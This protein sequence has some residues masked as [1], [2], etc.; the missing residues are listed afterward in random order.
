MQ[1]DGIFS[2][3]KTQYNASKSFYFLIKIIITSFIQVAYNTCVSKRIIFMRIF[4]RITI[5]ISFHFLNE[6]LPI[7]IIFIIGNT[8]KF[9]MYQPT[10]TDTSETYDKSQ[11]LDEDNIFPSG[12][13]LIQVYPPEHGP[14]QSH[15]KFKLENQ[16]TSFA[17][18]QTQSFN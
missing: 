8:T 6:D 13:D 11:K 4:S 9:W 16:S 2:Y 1:E 14:S 17:N 3:T 18:H 10:Q 5:N 15:T 12:I 7:S